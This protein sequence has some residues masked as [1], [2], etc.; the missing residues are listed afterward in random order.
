MAYMNSLLYVGRYANELGLRDV[1]SAE[2]S[3]CLDDKTV[4]C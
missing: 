2:T 3:Y 1:P 4:F